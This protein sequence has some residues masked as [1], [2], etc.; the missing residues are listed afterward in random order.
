MRPNQ[1]CQNQRRRVKK[2]ETSLWQSFSSS[3]NFSIV[4]LPLVV[5]K[6]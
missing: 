5:E 4:S 6:A 3:T 1:A 2:L